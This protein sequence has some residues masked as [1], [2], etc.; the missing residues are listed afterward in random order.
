MTLDDEVYSGDIDE[1][2]YKRI[3]DELL[4]TISVFK[5]R[6]KELESLNSSITHGDS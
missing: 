6:V 4:D 5:K 1:A 2:F 3:I